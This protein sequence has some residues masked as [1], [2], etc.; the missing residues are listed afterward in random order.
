MTKHL[1]PP[2]NPRKKKHNHLHLAIKKK[3]RRTVALLDFINWIIKLHWKFF[4][5][6]VAKF[7]GQDKVAQ[8]KASSPPKIFLHP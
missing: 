7:Y 1:I 4:G 6:E 3:T 5:N 2:W 8:S